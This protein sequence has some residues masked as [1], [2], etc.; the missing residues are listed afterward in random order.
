MS[1][2][3]PGL[4]L[5]DVRVACGKIARYLAGLHQAAFLADDKTID[6][7]VL[8]VGLRFFPENAT[9]QSCHSH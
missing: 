8:W 1:K 9:V 2:R 3:E 7:V 6:A 5:D 4:L